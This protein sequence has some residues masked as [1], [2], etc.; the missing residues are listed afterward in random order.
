MEL[1]Q[2]EINRLLREGKISQPKVEK[3]T[4]KKGDP[5]ITALLSISYALDGI[6]KKMGAGD[7]QLQP[8][9][10][11]EPA[12][13]TVTPNITVDNNGSTKW[14]FSIERDSTGRIKE[15]T[16]ERLK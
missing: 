13:V 3:P 8:I 16:A 9:V 15:V 11:I 1:S 2:K 5:N 7:K 4:K 6:A 14:K 12:E 10:K